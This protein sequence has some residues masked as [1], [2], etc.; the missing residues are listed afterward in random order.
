MKRRE[1]C[2]EDGCT[3][4]GVLKGYCNAHFA[5]AKRRGEFGGPPCVEDGCERT[6][7]TRGYC[8][9]HY[10]TH[11]NAGEFG[12]EL[13]LGPGCDRIG[14]SRGMCRSHYDQWR[15]GGELRF[16]Y[17]NRGEW[18]PWAIDANGRAI[19]R[20]TVDGVRETQ[21]RSRYVMEQKLGRP[22]EKHERVLHINGVADDD[23]PENLILS[24]GKKQ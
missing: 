11:R 16:I 5:G 22:L 17:Q 7:T 24:V 15:K 3:R 10:E 4:T 6:A 8:T 2:L 19:R 12:G 21:Y 18:G 23:A 20:R 9:Q 1:Q 13:C 14:V